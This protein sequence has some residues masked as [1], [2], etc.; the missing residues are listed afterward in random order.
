MNDCKV[1][2]LGCG[3]IGTRVARELARKGAVSRLALADI[4]V[5][6]AKKLASEVSGLGIAVSE[7]Q[8]DVNDSHALTQLLEGADLVANLTMPL[9]KTATTVAD[10]AIKVKANYIDAG[11]ADTPTIIKLMEL[12][13]RAKEAGVTV[14]TCLGLG[15]GLANILARYGADKLDEVDEIHTA[16]ISTGLANSPPEGIPFFTDYIFRYTYGRN[17]DIHKNGQ[18]VRIPVAS[19]QETIFFPGVSFSFD[20]FSA[21]HPE[22]V[23]IP[24]FIKGVKTVTFKAA[25]GTS[26]SKVIRL[27][28][29][30]PIM[31]N[32]LQ[33]E[34]KKIELDWIDLAIAYTKLEL[35]RTGIKKEPLVR[36]AWV[37]VIGRKNGRHAQYSYTCEDIHDNLLHTNYELGVEMLLAKKIN[38]H[39]VIAPESLDAEPFIQSA[40]K[41]GAVI[42]ESSQHTL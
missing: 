40:L 18:L 4:T 10:A 6:K 30:N 37:K 38:Q 32:N 1:V 11:C 8:L 36:G 24:R 29:G 27:L 15:P 26:I 25:Y 21:S 9:E 31:T 17:A 5:E 42:N 23:T 20:A 35:M 33:I 16:Y 12:D 34:G 7:T 39:G 13:K 14:L 22:V 28:Q 19:E 3:V 2:I 41:Q